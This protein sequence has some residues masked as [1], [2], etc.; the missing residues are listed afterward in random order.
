MN[1][2]TGVTASIQ[3]R[4]GQDQIIVQPTCDGITTLW[5]P[6]AKAPEILRYLKEGISEPFRVLYDLTA[7]DERTRSHRQGQ[8][9]SDFT[10]QARSQK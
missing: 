10:V 6:S 5:V 4:F 2:Q 8:P 3:E 1:E 9:E 7:I